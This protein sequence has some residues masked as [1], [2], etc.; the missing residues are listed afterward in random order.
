[1]ERFR[2]GGAE[3]DA[4]DT[5]GFRMEQHQRDETGKRFRDEDDSFAGQPGSYKVGVVP[6]GKILVVG[7]GYDGLRDIWRQGMEERPETYSCAI[8]AGHEDKPYGVRTDRHAPELFRMFL[9]PSQRSLAISSRVSLVADPRWG[10]RTV[11]GAAHHPGSMSG[12][13]S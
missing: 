5:G 11:R 10:S 13:F 7:I 1:M 6:E 2:E 3:D 4:F 12:S 9:M 8:E